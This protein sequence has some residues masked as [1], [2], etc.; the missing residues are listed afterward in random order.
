MCPITFLELL[1]SKR[2][3]KTEMSH[4]TS[5]LEYFQCDM[6]RVYV[7]KD[8]F[9]P[10]RRECKG[11]HST[12]LKKKE[13]EKISAVLDAAIRH[14]WAAGDTP[15]DRTSSAV[16]STP[17][18]VAGVSSTGSLAWRERREEQRV[19]RQVADQHVEEEK[20]KSHMSPAEIDAL[21][22]LI[23]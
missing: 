12:E 5:D 11:P 15:T 13:C 8:I 3:K 16:L 22:A 1:N 17:Q 23:E 10:H 6:C 4:A 14:R 19:R 21:L 9:C 2:E 20:M 18:S 7:H